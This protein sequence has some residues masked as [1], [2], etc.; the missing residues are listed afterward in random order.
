M[1]ESVSPFVHAGET[2]IFLPISKCRET[3]AIVRMTQVTREAIH[4]SWN[5][6]KMSR[7]RT[8]AFSRGQKPGN[9]LI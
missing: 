6:A 2:D 8:S 9:A 1:C 3:T 5:T 7:N 4:R